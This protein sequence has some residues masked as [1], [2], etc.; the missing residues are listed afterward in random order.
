M[1]DILQDEDD[2]LVEICKKHGVNPHYLR[3]LFSIEKEYADKNMAKRRG[4]FD[5][6]SDS[7]EEWVEEEEA[8]M[9]LL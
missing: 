8:E 4:L 1:A 7:I 9:E 5:R 6:I 2:L 3:E